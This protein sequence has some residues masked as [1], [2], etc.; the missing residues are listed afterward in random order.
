MLDNSIKRL[1][2]LCKVI[3]QLL[4][5]IDEGEFSKKPAPDKWSKKEILGHL[6][7]SATNNHHR[8][9]RGQFEEQPTIGYDNDVWNKGNHFQKLQKEELI[10]MWTS[11]NKYF[12]ALIKHIPGKEL[13]RLVKT[14][15]AGENNILTIAFII[16]DYVA[17][18]EHHLRQLVKY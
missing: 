5:N 1:E 12:L 3:P 11:Y 8:I 4:R 2:Y 13:K 9:V 6:I 15:E 17:H 10:E 14:G 7:A 18:L 16:E